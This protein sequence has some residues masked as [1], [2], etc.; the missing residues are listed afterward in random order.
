M[1]NKSQNNI[2]LKAQYENY[3]ELLN[4]YQKKLMINQTIQ[5]MSHETK[6]I[7]FNMI[8]KKNYGW[9]NVQNKA[10]RANL[11]IQEGQ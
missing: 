2:N 6:P 8:S 11:V 1:E 9:L 3:Q 7:T 5:Q 4:Q 10:G